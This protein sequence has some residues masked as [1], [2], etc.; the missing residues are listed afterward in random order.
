MF[1]LVLEFDCDSYNLIQEF[2]NKRAL[3]CCSTA[4][5][6]HWHFSRKGGSS[7]SRNKNSKE[8]LF[9]MIPSND[10]NPPGSLLF[11]FH[12]IRRRHSVFV[13]ETLAEIGHTAESYHIGYF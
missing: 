8:E 10:Q 13:L 3:Y 4:T 2:Y 7:G 6:F 11:L 9:R 5:T 12:I 1:R